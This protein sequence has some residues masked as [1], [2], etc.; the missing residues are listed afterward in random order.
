MSGSGGS[1]EGPTA[2]SVGDGPDWRTIGHDGR[3]IWHDHRIHVQDT[4]EFPGELDWSVPIIVDDLAVTIEGRLV[5][6]DPPSPLP[7]LAAGRGRRRGHLVRRAVT[8]PGWS[9]R[10]G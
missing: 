8:A 4:A 7:F 1:S 6:V 3:L 9:R 2:G 5:R 10:P